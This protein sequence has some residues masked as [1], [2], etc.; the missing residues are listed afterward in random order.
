MNL[1]HKRHTIFHR[2]VSIFINL[3][4]R[5]DNSWKIL[6]LK[7][8]YSEDRDVVTSLSTNTNFFKYFFLCRTNQYIQTNIVFCSIV[9]KNDFKRKLHSKVRR[10]IYARGKSLQLWRWYICCSCVWDLPIFF[11]TDD[12]HRNFAE[13]ELRVHNVV[14]KHSSYLLRYRE[15]LRK[16]GD[17]VWIQTSN[18]YGTNSFV[19]ANGNA[20][21]SFTGMLIHEL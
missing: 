17:H 15:H 18:V 5:W 4:I 21:S 1:I 13:T 12:H 7:V 6:D 8:L 14:I 10:S 16:K 9:T 3:K 2:D 11:D 19:V 20:K